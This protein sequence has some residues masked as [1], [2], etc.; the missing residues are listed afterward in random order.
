LARIRQIGD[1]NSLES[2][3]VSFGVLPF[4]LSGYWEQALNRLHELLDRLAH[5]ASSESSLESGAHCRSVVGWTGDLATVWVGAM[6]PEQR[7]AHF[8]LLEA[9]LQYRASM[10]RIVTAAVATAASL[11]AVAGSPLMAPAALRSVMK[12]I[13]ELQ[14]V[15]QHA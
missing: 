8:A 9:D 4:D 6:T 11:C 3:A 2:E 12:L 5:F 1:P 10:I 15:R 13:A 7:Q 14:N